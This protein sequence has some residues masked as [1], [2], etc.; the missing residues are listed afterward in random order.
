[1]ELN[2][3]W[4]E[5]RWRLR[6]HE[7]IVNNIPKE[8]YLPMP[9][10]IPSDYADNLGRRSKMVIKDIFPPPLKMILN[11]YYSLPG[12]LQPPRP[13]PQSDAPPRRPSVPTRR[14]QQC[15]VTRVVMADKTTVERSAEKVCMEESTESKMEPELGELELSS[16]GTGLEATGQQCLSNWEMERTTVDGC[17]LVD[18]S[19]DLGETTFSLE[20]LVIW[21]QTESSFAS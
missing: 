5:T 17:L 12:Q 11:T 2:A 15:Y 9:L 3:C 8:N 13:S 18:G 14:Q 16:A 19:S 7:G 4:K 21:T 6:C 20:E 1:M 10:P